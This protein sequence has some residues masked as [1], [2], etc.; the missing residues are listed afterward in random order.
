MAGKNDVSV[1]AVRTSDARGF[2][3]AFVSVA[4]PPLELERV[5]RAASSC[6]RFESLSAP[7]AVSIDESALEGAK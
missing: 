3:S 7:G 2:G 5:Q 4:A 1:V 6:R